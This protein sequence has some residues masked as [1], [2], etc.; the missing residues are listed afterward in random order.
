MKLTEAEWKALTG[1]LAYYET[2]LEDQPRSKR[3]ADAL[4][5]AFE[6]I[7]TAAGR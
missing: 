5:R 7:R 6:K 4:N 3:E 2:V 1:A